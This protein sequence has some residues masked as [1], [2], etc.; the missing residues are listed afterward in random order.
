MKFK[1]RYKYSKSFQIMEI[2]QIFESNKTNHT[3]FISYIVPNELAT[4]DINEKNLDW[5]KEKAR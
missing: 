3:F 2:N 4:T 1:Y 5:L